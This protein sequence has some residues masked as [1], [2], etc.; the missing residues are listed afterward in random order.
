M[1]LGG[2]SASSFDGNP[3]RPR[4]VSPVTSRRG[5]FG[6]A[7]AGS[8]ASLGGGGPEGSRMISAEAGTPPLA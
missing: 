3:L 8:G 5:E 2:S 7:V 1:V 4:S 6:D